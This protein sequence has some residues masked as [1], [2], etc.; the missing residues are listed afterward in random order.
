MGKTV[1]DVLVETLI[2]W[3]VDTIFGL[4]GDG[5]DGVMEALRTHQDQIRFVLVRHEEAGAFAAC[6]YAKFTGK[7]GACISTSGPGAIHLLNGLYDAKLDGV[8]VIAITGEPESDLIGLHYQQ[9]VDVVRLFEDVAAYNQQ[10]QGASDAYNL[11]NTA[12]RTA[13]A[14]RAVA[15]LTIPID[16]QV[17]DAQEQFDK[18]FSGPPKTPHQ[19]SIFQPAYYAQL[20]LT[21]SAGAQYQQT[22]PTP[23]DA[24]MRE[25]AQILN[26]ASKVAILAGHGAIHARQELLAVAE[27]L[28]ASIVKPLLGK[29]V[30]GDDNPYTTGG[31]GLL[32][33]KPS[34]DAM[35][36]CDALLIVGSSFPYSGYLPK[37]GQAAGIQIDIDQARLGLRYPIDVGLVGDAQATLRALIS[38]L[39]KKADRSFLEQAQKGMADW[40]KM[41]EKEGTST[42]TPMHP[43]VLAW[44]LSELAAPNAIICGDSGTNTTWLARNFILREDQMFSCSGTL[45][46]MGPGVPYAIAAQV[47]YPDRQV[48][49]FVGDGGFTMMMFEMLT[50]VHYNLPIKVVVVKNNVL[51]Q[52]KWEQMVFLGNP[53]FGVE[54]QPANWAGWAKAAGAEGYSCDDPTKLKDVMREFLASPRPALLESYVNPNE[55]PL[56]P[57]ITSKQAIHFAE[58]LLKGEPNG[59]R[60]A[61]TAFRE[62]F[63]QMVGS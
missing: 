32:G 19:T 34:D 28:G 43:Q 42:D 10:I 59:P 54:L 61:L 33:T 62:K 5:I 16:R 3:G 46:T 1:S 55:P 21:R 45:A 44:T 17:E 63:S 51:G 23:P 26:S 9:D 49:A 12:C 50:A 11:T 13:L 20:D 58:A 40:R 52:I 29:G 41:L 2:A 6:A 47:A 8:P 25:A 38:L 14:Q 37:P 24:L 7:L 27:L 57:N 4:P 18:T 60:I 15:H 36:H 39:R 30:V 48:I 35:E 22:A 31:I 53:Q 56:P